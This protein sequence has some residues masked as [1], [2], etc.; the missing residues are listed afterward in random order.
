MRYDEQINF[1]TTSSIKEQLKTIADSQGI[2]V[3]QLVNEIVVKYLD[4]Q[5][6]SKSADVTLQKVYEIVISQEK[7]LETLE[8]K[9]A[10]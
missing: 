1:R 4:S 7:R 8:K 10:A 5:N 9:S 6:A 3:S 2:K